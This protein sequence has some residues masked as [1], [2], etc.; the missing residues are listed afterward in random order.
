MKSKY[1]LW[2]VVALLAVV[3]LVLAFRPAGAKVENVDA[4]GVQAAIDSGAQVIDVRTAG[5][6]Q[7]G[8]VPGAVNVPVDQIEAEA[9]GWDK[10]GTYVIYCATGSRSVSAVESMKAL[11]FT[12]IKHFNAGIQAWNGQ[13]EKGAASSANKIQTSGKPVLIEFYTDS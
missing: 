11:G 1:V 8:H 9:Q 13:L 12:D 6:Y 10:G 2:G 3:V 5:E 4:A 7:L